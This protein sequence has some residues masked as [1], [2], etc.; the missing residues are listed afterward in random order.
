MLATVAHD[1]EKDVVED[2]TRI[3]GQTLSHLGLEPDPLG[4]ALVSMSAVMWAAA[5]HPFVAGLPRDRL[6]ALVDAY[7]GAVWGWIAERFGVEH[8]RYDE[9]V[10]R[11]GGLIIPNEIKSDR[12]LRT[13]MHDILSVTVRQIGQATD[14][15][16]AASKDKKG[17]KGLALGD[18][19][20]KVLFRGPNEVRADVAMLTTEM[21]MEEAATAGGALRD[22]ERQGV[23][24]V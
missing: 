13:G 24:M 6:A 20:A 22:L 9:F 5:H 2:C 7:Y 12:A 15:Y 10:H 14:E 23:Q 17:A 18:T 4:V 11:L 8:A 21:F 19:V 1:A 16:M 3:V